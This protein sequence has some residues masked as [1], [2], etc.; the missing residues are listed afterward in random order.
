MGMRLSA[1]E[2]TSYSLFT[3]EGSLSQGFWERTSLL[4]KKDFRDNG[5]FCN[6]H[7]HVYKRPG[8][9]LPT[10]GEMMLTWWLG[11]QGEEAGK[12]VNP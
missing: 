9:R 7:H 5:H 11:W 2:R 1:G 4:I 8:D 3:A 10:L 6:P 12:S